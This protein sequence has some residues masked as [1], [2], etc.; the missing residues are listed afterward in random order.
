MVSSPESPST[1]SLSILET[2][3][4]LQRLG[5]PPLPECPIEAAK[6]GKEP[7]APCFFDGRRVVSISWKQWQHTQPIGEIIKAWFSHPKTGIGTLGGWNG[8]H[9]LCWADFD[10]KT[11]ESQDECDRAISSWQTRYPILENAPLFK[12]PSGGYRFLIAFNQEPKNFKANSGFSLNSDGS[13][14]VGELLTK[15]G[16]HTLLPPTVGVT[17]TPYQWVRWAEYPPVVE[18]PADVG[19]YPVINQPT[20]LPTADHKRSQIYQDDNQLTDLLQREIY[21]RLSPDRLFIWH[22]HE[23]KEDRSGKLRGC[24]P[25]HESKSGTAFYAEQQNGTW[26]WRCPAC[27]IGGGPLEYRYRLAGG[28][29]SPRGREFV[30]LVKALAVEVGV[31]FPE[32]SH[33]GHSGNGH[34]S[35]RSVTPAVV[36][37]V[38]THNRESLKDSISVL[39]S[40]QLPDSDLHLE[41]LGLS[42]RIGLPIRELEKLYRVKEAESFQQE[43]LTQEKSQLDKLLNYQIKAQFDFSEILPPPLYRAFATKAE[44]DRLDM[45][46]LVQNLWPA[47]TPLVGGKI[48]IVAKEGVSEKDSWIEYANVWSVVVD[49]PSKGKSNSDRA[50]FAPL[51]ALQDK[52]LD[53]WEKQQEKL[54]ELEEEWGHKSKQERAELADSLDNPAVY[55]ATQ[56]SCRKY[57]FD[58]GEI[59]AIKRRLAEQP[60][61]AGGCWNSGELMKIFNSLDQ[62]KGGKGSARD[63]LLD[64]WNGLLWG[65]TDRVDSQKSFRF[66]NQLLSLTGGIQIDRARKFFNPT[67][68]NSDTDGLQSRLLVAV[69]TTHTLFAKW[70][71]TKVDIHETLEELYNRASLCP[72]GLVRFSPEAKRVWVSQWEKF[73][74]GYLKYEHSNPAFAYFLGK[75]CS[76]FLRLALSLHIVEHCYQPKL[77]FFQIELE[78]AQKASK[79]SDYYIGQ[80]RLLQSKFAQSPDDGLPEFLF[81]ILNLCLAEGSLTP[82]RVIDKWRRRGTHGKTG[83]FKTA[84][85]KKM[86]ETI[87]QARP[88]LVEYDGQVLKAN[89][90]CDH[91]VIRNDQLDHKVKPNNNKDSSD[92]YDQVIRETSTKNPKKPLSSDHFYDHLITALPETPV[93]EAKN[94]AIA[95]II[96][97]RKMITTNGPLEPIQEAVIPEAVSTSNGVEPISTA[98]TIEFASSTE[99]KT[100]KSE[101][102]INAIACDHNTNVLALEVGS[103]VKVYCLGSKHHGATGTVR[104]IAELEDKS[105]E[106]WVTLKKGGKMTVPLPGTERFHVEVLT[107]KPDESDQGSAQQLELSPDQP[108]LSD[109]SVSLLGEMG[110]SE[111]VRDQPVILQPAR[112]EPYHAKTNP[113]KKGDRIRNGKGKSGQITEVRATNP[114]Y[115]VRWDSTGA[116]SDYDFTDLQILDIRREG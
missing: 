35:G 41:L 100:A 66:S 28:N 49:S 17:G 73:R 92:F 61:L 111:V 91:L 64:L 38:P 46:Y 6:Q 78:T 83:S 84:E 77:N 109:L 80:F 103:Q 85:V 48:G 37:A 101:N 4:W 104:R 69:P 2:I 39:V 10:A 60:P 3:A 59:E 23:F 105:K 1:T 107:E 76:N 54:A 67:G 116:R 45:V 31:S 74:A 42:Q 82:R 16:G 34:T 94:D 30:D 58:D 53:R 90:N 36:A 15:N 21:P 13:H 55:K 40:Q 98:K 95:L 87:A 26:L 86:F 79:L 99:D 106:V 96:S 63:F 43:S 102:V 75:M 24:C 81:Q 5:R 72:S 14:H 114:K 57:L 56:L 68:D 20:V 11:F 113:P 33:N 88:Q 18:Q 8:R 19:L 112:P 93:V 27:D 110:L 12:T 47:L 62:Y 7:K 50:I 70:S 89:K 51:R 32:L 29:G 97:D 9:W 71:D 25:W 108:S 22:G 52:E 65:T 115:T 44:S